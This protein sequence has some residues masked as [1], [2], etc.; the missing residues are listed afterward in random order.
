M[1]LAITCLICLWFSLDNSE[2]TESNDGGAVVS[3]LPI[4]VLNRHRLPHEAIPAVRTPLGIADDYKPWVVQCKDGDLLIVGFCYYGEPY[5][6]RAV[7]WRSRDGGRTW[8]PRQERKDV[9]GR[10][11]S[12]T[13]LSDG[14]LIMP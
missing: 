9:R 14:T 6:E 8:G 1:R 2:A 13:C 7:F 10:E 5:A 3:G 4:K 12:L 11:F